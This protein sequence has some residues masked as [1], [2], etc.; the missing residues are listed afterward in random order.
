MVGRWSNDFGGYFGQYREELDL[1]A[2][3]TADQR[4]ATP[5]FADDSSSWLT[6]YACQWSVAG[7]DTP[8][9]SAP[10]ILQT[11]CT[12]ASR[13]LPTGNPAWTQDYTFHGET[14]I[15]AYRITAVAPFSF[16]E[17]VGI[18]VPAWITYS[19]EP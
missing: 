7:V 1:R 15:G 18:D 11:G 3:G 17:Q 14:Y 4:L 6:H 10:W 12:L 13:S 19:R 8:R 2:D 16:V 9:P 5:G